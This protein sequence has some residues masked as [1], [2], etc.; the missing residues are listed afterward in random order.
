MAFL[1]LHEIANIIVHDRIGI[2][3]LLGVYKLNII[4]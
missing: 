1:C 3:S 2:T 4:K